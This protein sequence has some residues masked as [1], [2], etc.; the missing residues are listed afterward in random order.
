LNL[1]S[2]PGSLWTDSQKIA[3]QIEGAVRAQVT[4][5]MQEWGNRE[6]TVALV[7][8]LKKMVHDNE[9]ILTEAEVMLE[10]S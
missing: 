1:L 9:S 3:R 10:N 5:E 4:S 2:P 8:D 6:E 7:N